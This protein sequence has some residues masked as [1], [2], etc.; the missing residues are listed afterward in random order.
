MRQAAIVLYIVIQKNKKIKTKYVKIIKQN[1][2][3]LNYKLTILNLQLKVSSQIADSIKK[4]L[5]YDNI[6]FSAYKDRK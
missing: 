6:S 2:V 1:Q 4:F 5:I 3:T